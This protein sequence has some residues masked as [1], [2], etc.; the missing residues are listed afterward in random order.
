MPYP[1][2]F[3]PHPHR[4]R[5]AIALAPQRKA[6]GNVATA[7]GLAERLQ[8]VLAEPNKLPNQRVFFHRKTRASVM[9]LPSAP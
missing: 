7:G 9:P 6:P 1:S 5:L 4:H 8:L 3:F 2:Q